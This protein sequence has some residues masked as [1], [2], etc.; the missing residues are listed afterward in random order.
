MIDAKSVLG[1]FPADG[2]DAALLRQERVVILDRQPVVVFEVDLA[3][4]P[5][6][7]GALLL[8]ELRIFRPSAPLPRIDL[9]A[10]GCDPGAIVGA[11]AR[12]VFRVLR[13]SL[14]L[15]RGIAGNAGAA[16]FLPAS[17]VDLF[18][19]R[20][21]PGAVAGAQSLAMFRGSLHDA[22]SLP[23]VPAR[24]RSRAATIRCRVRH[25][26]GGDRW[27]PSRRGPPRCGRTRRE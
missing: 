14:F 3:L 21:V 8:P 20:G 17:R 6:A 7:I 11:H 15:P 19:V 9:V 2:A 13:I 24:A 10:V 22:A 16:P 1:W 23:G 4:A 26:S 5:R 25:C 12:P 27:T 18:L